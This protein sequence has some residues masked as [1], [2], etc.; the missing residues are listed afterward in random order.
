[1][2]KKNSLIKEVK[3]YIK[4]YENDI[5]WGLEL[6]F[7]LKRLEAMESSI[8][9]VGQFSVGKSAL[10]NALLGE[11]FLSTRK[12]ESTKIITRIRNCEKKKDA[13]IVLTNLDG[14]ESVL[15]LKN[16]KD[17]Q[18]YTTF[19]GEEITDSL[20]YVDVYWPVNFLNKELVLIDTPGANSIT[21]SA[22]KTTQQQLKS[23]SAI[24]YL[25][26]GT[27]GLDKEDYILINE[28]VKNKKKLFLVGTQ[29]D[30]L[31]K[32]QWNE[33]VTEVTNEIEKLGIS[34]D[35]E[36]VGISSVEALQAKR[37]NNDELLMKSNI[38]KLE[39]IL[40]SYMDSK[41]YEKSEIRSIEHDYLQL[42]NEIELANEE[43]LQVEE[44]AAADRKRR[45]DRLIA[46]TEKEYLDVEQFGSMLI[47]NRTT[48][49]DVLN[50]KNRNELMEL[51]N[52]VLKSVEK[53][54]VDFQNIIK[55]Q[56]NN[57]T[58]FSSVDEVKN[59][60]IKHL[61]EIEVIYAK[62][63]R[64][65]E[66]FGQKYVDELEEEIHKQD[67]QFA[68]KLK[69]IETNIEIAWEEFDV[70]L[71]DLKMKPLKLAVDLTDFNLYETNKS[72]L[73]DKTDVLKKKISENEKKERELKKE[74]Q[75]ESKE[76]LNDK[77][78]EESSLGSK[79]EP[80][81]IYKTKGILFWK[82]EE[83][84]GY[85]YSKQERW[86]ERMSR[87]QE[88]YQQK[89]TEINNNYLNKQK[90]IKEKQSEFQYQ[91][92]ELEDADEVESQELFGALFATVSNQRTIVKEQHSDQV[93]KMKLEWKILS[94]VQEERCYNHI[95]NIEENFRE[96][97]MKSKNNAINSLQVL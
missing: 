43:L 12:V 38:S 91:L 14:E 85:D 8:A 48:Q 41:E 5:F 1:M 58:E 19:Q 40:F 7:L 20:K 46:L 37:E 29:I 96:F 66:Q 10:L 16:A 70:I 74:K 59:T 2:D 53:Q 44:V 69:I 28:Y 54:Y 25:F 36:I 33:V 49:L 71:H 27:K 86:D 50:V 80:K 30:R 78:N 90:E 34:N 82:R 88:S 32:E 84:M 45:L 76:A 23:S 97:V 57:A 42:V 93:N 72:K 77:K 51:G 9:V 39:E 64:Y 89:M 81:E 67:V 73:V 21:A 60:Y 79:P 17:I 13:R 31:S 75:S 18:K 35:L 15:P 83:F 92:E 65:L 94:E 4:E 24:I 61:N 47:K 3:A 68:E 55:S 62:W 63:D 52:E 22:F 26:M 11:E 95:Q 56:L 6:E 87:I